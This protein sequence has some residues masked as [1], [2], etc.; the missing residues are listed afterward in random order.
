MEA[1]AIESA[2]TPSIA[3]RRIAVPA[4]RWSAIFAGAVAGLAT[5]MLLSLL[6][7]AVG[8]T[9]VEATGETAAGVPIVTAIWSSIC[10]LIAAFVGGYVAARMSGLARRT[11][12]VLH[13]FVA[14]ATVM[15]LFVWLATT[16]IGNLLGG[17]FG[18]VA[19]GTQTAAASGQGGSI[20]QQIQS[21]IGGTEGAQISG[22][23]L[24][25]VQDRLQ[26]GDR[27]GAVDYMVNQ[28]GFS[29][30]RANTIAD[31]LEPL[32]GSEGEGAAQA[33]MDALSAASWWLFIAIALSLV[34]GLWGG[35]MGARA[36]SDRTLGD[37]S[38]ER[39]YRTF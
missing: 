2:V 31:N 13:G 7:V 19:Q 12:G 11:D 6:G 25:A 29:E 21:I 37:H 18:L 27:A 22:E 24:G 15:V 35:L 17:A 20:A 16:A 32:L 28:M 38:D 34:M 14:W 3:S 5:Y 4:I 39:H 26:A 36:T 8:L 1:H 23:D 33:T 30:E 9:A 10:M